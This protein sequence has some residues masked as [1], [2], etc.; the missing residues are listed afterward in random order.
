MMS[1]DLPAMLSLA[2]AIL[3]ERGGRRYNEDAC[4]HWHSARHL[5]CVLA[6]GAGGHGGGDIAARYA[7]QRLIE[8]FAARPVVDG[9]D[10]ADL[11]RAANRGLIALREPG[12]ERAEMHSTAVCLAIDY[13][14]ASAGW[15][16]TGDSRL[17][18]FRDGR[19]VERTQDHSVVQALVDAGLLRDEALREHPKRSEL[20]S[21]LGV[22]DEEL[23]ISDSGP[24]CALQPGDRFLL[25]SDGVWEHVADAQLEALLQRAASPEAWLAAIEAAVLDATRDRASH[26]NF[27][28]LTVWATAAAGA[29]AT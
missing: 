17:Y 29:P 25:C 8:D 15:A 3:S 26:D 9:A 14:A 20:L 18:W 19:L 6:D 23:R 21:A 13:Q 7:V 2:V 22:A 4:G 28:A 11:L 10:L 24:P 1:D 27:S 16:H 5:C 12:T